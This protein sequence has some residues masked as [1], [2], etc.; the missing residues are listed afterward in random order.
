MERTRGGQEE[1]KLTH[2]KFLGYIREALN[3]LQYPQRLRRSPLADL[4]GVAKRFDTF[5]ALQ[6]ILIEGIEALEPDVDELPQS[7][8]LRIYESLQGRYVQRLNQQEIADQLN[9][10]P[11]QVRREQR[12]A[13]ETLADHL[14]RQFD[15]EAKLS[16]DAGTEPVVEARSTLN[17]ELAWLEDAPPTPSTDLNQTLASVLDLAQPLADQHDVH[18]ELTAP[19]SLP[20]LAVHPVAL[21]QIL[22]SLLSVAYHMASD[23][24]VNTAANILNWEVEIRVQGIKPSSAPHTI[25]DED[26]ASLDLARKLTRLSEGTLKTSNDAGSFSATLTLPALEQVPVL[27]ID[28][29]ADTL[30][31]LQR[32]ASHTRYRLAT[33]RDPQRALDL[34]RQLSPQIIVLDVMMPDMDGWQVLRRLRG[35]PC[36][37][38][39]SLVVCTVVRQKELAFSLGAD[40]FIEKPVSRRTF[41]DTLDQQLTEREP[42]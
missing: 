11:R 26:A 24:R 7:R 3:H 37:A 21:K 22:L 6:E 20:E 36:T 29:N 41:L 12:A 19:G 15:L 30:R 31:L 42:R 33:T 9:L 1:D 2:E 16:Q 8:A 32:Y 25:S 28:D 38:H 17:E 18:Q 39:T 27:V 23:G 40:A 13:L 5:L 4:F 14:W 34:T 35:H 10:S